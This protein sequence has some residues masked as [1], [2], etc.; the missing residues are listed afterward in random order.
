M[1]SP[2]S[3]G[4]SLQG[5]SRSNLPANFGL[6]KR[7]ASKLWIASRSP[8]A[9]FRDAWRPPCW[10]FS[11]DF[12]L[13]A[14]MVLCRAASATSLELPTCSNPRPGDHPERAHGGDEGV[15][16]RLRPR[17]QRLRRLVTS[18]CGQ[19]PSPR[20]PMTCLNHSGCGRRRRYIGKFEGR[21]THCWG[22]T[23]PARGVGR[24]SLWDLNGLR[25]G[26]AG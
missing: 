1:S 18:R 11:G 17:V 21:T 9:I 6:P 3:L 10:Q 20:N 19:T 22:G 4:G 25:R 8:E 7:P 16:G 2:C 12:S 15:Q 5:A 24:I 23:T 13:S 14:I 26:F